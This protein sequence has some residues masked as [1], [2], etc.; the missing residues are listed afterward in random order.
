MS[1]MVFSNSTH[2]YEQNET[3]NANK[4]QADLS[5]TKNNH[6]E[7]RLKPPICLLSFGPQMDPCGPQ[8]MVFGSLVLGCTVCGS[9]ILTLTPD[10]TV[11]LVTFSFD[12]R[13][14]SNLCRSSSFSMG[15]HLILKI[16]KS[17]H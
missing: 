16:I 14:A 15:F 5:E 10:F 13:F 7:I 3:K 12:I 11:L 8:K 9:Q 17:R 6:Q 2:S 1:S 4:L